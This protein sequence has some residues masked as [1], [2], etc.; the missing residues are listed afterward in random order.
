VQRLSDLQPRDVRDDRRGNCCRQAFDVQLMDRL[1]ESPGFLSNCDRRADQLE[2]YL[3]LDGTF[4]IDQ[5]K[6]HV[7]WHLL[8]RLVLDI[9]DD[10]LLRAFDPRDG[11]IDQCVFARGRHELYEHLRVDG[12]V[13]WFGPGP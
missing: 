11:E 12:D 3:D 1:G 13:Q 8:E 6:V 4:E 7:D 2:R 5:I 9:A 10:N